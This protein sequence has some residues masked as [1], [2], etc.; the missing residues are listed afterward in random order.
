MRLTYHIATTLQ[1]SDVGLDKADRKVIFFFLSENKSIG[2]TD[3]APSCSPLI[4]N[5]RLATVNNMLQFLHPRA[6][7]HE[8]DA[9]P[10]TLEYKLH[11]SAPS[12]VLHSKFAF[13]FA[14]ICGFGNIPRRHPRI[15]FG[16]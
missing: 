5:I 16:F 9:A 14:I 7:T 12:T 15:I 11:Y 6:Q 10:F 8:A 13:F 3:A 2:S 4:T 1:N